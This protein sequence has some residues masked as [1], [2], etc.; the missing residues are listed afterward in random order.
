MQQLPAQRPGLIL[1][2]RQT[3]R[4]QRTYQILR[5]RFRFASGGEPEAQSLSRGS[6]Y[7]FFFAVFLATFLVAALAVFFAFFAFLAMSS[8]MRLSLS[9]RAHA[10][11]RHA[12]Q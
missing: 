7:F 4:L 12:Q 8:S 10:V 11:H 6:D 2:C 5:D 3:V 9:E 1:P